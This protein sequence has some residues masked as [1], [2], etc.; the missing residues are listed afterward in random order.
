[1]W[2]QDRTKSVGCVAVDQRQDSVGD[3]DAVGGGL[4]RGWVRMAVWLIAVALSGFG[5]DG[6]H[7]R[8]GPWAAQDR[9]GDAL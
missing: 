4:A 2:K 3:P 7:A 6:V 9:P 1:V 8:S 5:G